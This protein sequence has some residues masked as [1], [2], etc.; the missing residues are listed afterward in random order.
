MYAARTGPV[1]FHLT[2]TGHFLLAH[3]P[4][5][6]VLLAMLA[7]ALLRAEV[8]GGVAWLRTD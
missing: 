7:P 4:V 6:G 5:A 2:A 1:D 3:L 8:E